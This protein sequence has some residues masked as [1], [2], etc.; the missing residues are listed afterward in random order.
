VEPPS[1]IRAATTGN[2]LAHGP[3]KTSV[4]LIANENGDA[5]FRVAV[6]IWI[7]INAMDMSLR[8]EVMLPHLERTAALID[9]DLYDL[10]RASAK[11][12]E[13]PV[14]DLEVVLP[15]VDEPIPVVVNKVFE[16]VH[17]VRQTLKKELSLDRRK[18]SSDAPSTAYSCRRC[19][20]DDRA[21]GIRRRSPRR[22]GDDSDFEPGPYLK[23]ALLSVLREDLGAGAMQ[24]AI[25]DDGSTRT[26]VVQTIDGLAPDHR[27]E[28]YRA[29]RN[30]GLASNC[31]RCLRLA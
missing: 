22:V 12:G 23:E 19:A 29:E 31:N 6:A 3:E 28:I 2:L 25:V 26:N 5:L 15:F 10:D 16:I 13:V 30:Q 20:P 11:G 8:S 21:R 4:L 27:V 24:I 1:S 18:S 17:D 7:H 14:V 9:A